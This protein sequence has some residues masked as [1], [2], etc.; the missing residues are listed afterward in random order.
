MKRSRPKPGTV[1]QIPLPDGKYAYGRVYDDAGLG[2]YRQVSDL[3]GRPPIGSRD[4]QFIV[5]V[6]NEYL[7]QVSVP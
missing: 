2:V 1:V 5:G 4:F 3:P 7:P 6:Y